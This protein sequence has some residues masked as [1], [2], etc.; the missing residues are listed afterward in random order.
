M[1]IAKSA[2]IALAGIVGLGAIIY[3]FRNNLTSGARS[4]GSTIGE[5]VGGFFGSIPTG[6]VGGIGESLTGG[7]EQSPSGTTGKIGFDVDTA[8]QNFVDNTQGFIDILNSAFGIKKNSIPEN[9]LP[10]RSKRVD[11]DFSIGENTFKIPVFNNKRY[12]GTQ[13]YKQFSISDVVEGGKFSVG[14]GKASAKGLFDVT[15]K[16][17][18]K[19]QNLP[20]SQYAIDFYKSVGAK[21]R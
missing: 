4:V 10:D 17:N 6:V 20:L 18:K 13:T 8:Q 2:G 3:I 14:S 9:Q 19:A 15:F 16:N 5:S 11:P 1:G 7:K 21:I 12:G